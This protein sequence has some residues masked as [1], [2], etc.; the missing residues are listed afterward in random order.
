MFII[1]LN[2]Y[3][4]PDIL[5]IPL[6][7]IGLLCNSQH[8]FIPASFAILGAIAGYSTLWIM[9]ILYKKITKKQLKN[10]LKIAQ[11][12]GLRKMFILGETVRG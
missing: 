1:D 4:L 3:L 2:H 11:L 6:L 10:T 5:T 7:W 8:L 12:I 9:H